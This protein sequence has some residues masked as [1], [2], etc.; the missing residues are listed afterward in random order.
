MYNYLEAV[1]NDVLEAMKGHDLTGKDRD[2]IETYLR[3]ELWIDDAVTGNGSGSY[4]FNRARARDYV[5]NSE[6]GAG[7]LVDAAKVFCIDAAEIGKRFIAEDWEYFDV[8]IRCYVL[9]QAIA[10]ALD[11]M[12]D[13]NA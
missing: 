3:D 9:D 4:T 10:A 7:L 11:E 5:L 2:E 12:E 8:T 13:E 6:D 1:K